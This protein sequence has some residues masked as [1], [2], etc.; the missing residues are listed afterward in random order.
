ME[1]VER[2]P[3][4]FDSASML[5]VCSYEVRKTHANMLGIS[6]EDIYVLENSIPDE[7][8]NHKTHS[9]NSTLKKIAVVSNHIPEEVFGLKDVAKDVEVTYFGSQTGNYKVITPEVLDEFDVVISIGKT[10][11]FTLGMG[12]PAYEYDHFGGNGYITLDNLDEEARHNFAGRNTQRKLTSE[13]I[14]NEIT[15]QYND[16]VAMQDELKEKAIDRFL[17]SKKLDRLMDA[18]LASKDF[19]YSTLNNAKYRA[20]MELDNGSMFVNYVGNYRK[21]E[22]YVADLKE[23]IH[24]LENELHTIVNSKAWKLI[25]K[26]RNLLPSKNK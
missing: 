1:L 4:Y 16:V 5:V 6:E 14:F 3:N 13:E 11:T 22:D 23:I 19:D 7:F 8:V 9:L 10:I 18:M 20:N 24:N 21:Q 17:L 25:T 15:T 26:V 12:I 2:F